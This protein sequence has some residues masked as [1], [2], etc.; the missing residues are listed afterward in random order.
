MLVFVIF[1]MILGER[2]GK[3]NRNELMNI[4]VKGDEA[5]YDKGESIDSYSLFE[6]LPELLRPRLAAKVLGLSVATIYDWKYRGK[7]RN[8]PSDLF[9]KLNRTLYIRTNVLKLW[10]ASY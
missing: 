3:L 8:I 6:N 1:K 2:M 10:V 7:M 5:G 9:L 4:D